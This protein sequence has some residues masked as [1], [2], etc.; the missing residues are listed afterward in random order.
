MRRQIEYKSAW[1]NRTVVAVDRFYPS[2]KTC[3]ACGSINRELQLRDTRWSCACGAVHDRDENAAKNIRAEALRLIAASSPATQRSGGSDA[4]GV[5]SAVA[6]VQNNA[7]PHEEPRIRRRSAARAGRQAQA[8][9]TT[10]QDP[11]GTGRS[12]VRVRLRSIFLTTYALKPRVS[13][14]HRRS[15]CSLPSVCLEAPRERG[16]L[17]AS[18]H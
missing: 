1:Q 12:G 13:G 2:S 14:E 3:S 17:Y 15:V 4:R 16:A 18:C 10:T 5:A 6:A 11:N 7:S 8:C 9:N